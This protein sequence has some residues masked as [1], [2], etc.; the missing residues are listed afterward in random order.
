MQLRAVYTQDIAAAI[1]A[2]QTE[3]ALPEA[4]EASCTDRPQHH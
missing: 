3:R 1:G 2:A 4:R